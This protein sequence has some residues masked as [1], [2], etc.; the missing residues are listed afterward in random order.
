VVLSRYSKGAK[1]PVSPPSKWKAGS[2]SLGG[3]GNLPAVPN[4]KKKD[5]FGEAPK[6]PDRAG[7]AKVLGFKEAKVGDKAKWIPVPKAGADE[8]DEGEGKVYAP[9]PQRIMAPPGKE[10]AMPAPKP[11][12]PPKE[13]PKQ[14]IKPKPNAPPEGKIR[15]IPKPIVVVEEEEVEEVESEKDSKLT[16][17]EELEEEPVSEEDDDGL[18]DLDEAQSNRKPQVA[19]VIPNNRRPGSG[20]RVIRP[21]P[22]AGAAK[23]PPPPPPPEDP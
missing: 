21:K 23:P 11:K 5:Q 9:P 16:L 10:M 7:E 17:D 3:A 15:K 12:P 2:D 18:G 6:I 4:V 1:T 14:V 8:L 20:G 19:A 22:V 13:L